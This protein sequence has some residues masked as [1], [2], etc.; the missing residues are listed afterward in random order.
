LKN[1]GKV[2][3]SCGVYNCQKMN[4]VVGAGIASVYFNELRKVF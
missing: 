2:I 4:F 3:D 1:F